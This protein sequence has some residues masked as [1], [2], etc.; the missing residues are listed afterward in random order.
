MILMILMI[1]GTP[2]DSYELLLIPTNSYGFL[3][4]AMLLY[5]YIVDVRPVS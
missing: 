2:T 3:I 4:I 1:L 5:I